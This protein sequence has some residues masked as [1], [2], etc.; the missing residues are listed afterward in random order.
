VT[1]T[2][3]ER[4]LVDLGRRLDWPEAPDLA[5]SVRAE[6]ESAPAVVVP[7]RR[8]PRRLVVLAAAALLVFGGLLA[9]SPGLRAALLE[10]LRLPGARIEIERTP[11]P[12]P[13]AAASP[14]LEDLVPGSE[15]SLAEA[16][17]TASFRVLLPSELGRPDAVVLFATGDDA[18]VTLAYRP[19]P[20]LPAADA[21]GY[22]VLLTEIRAEPT[23]ELIGKVALET[24]VEP[25]VVGGEQGYWIEGPHEVLLERGDT[26]V[27]D[28]PR[29]SASSLLWTRGPVTLRLEGDLSK[30]DALRLART[31]E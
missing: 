25:V 20:G 31:V 15:V 17:R 6:L 24:Q 16:R 28:A 10:L 27:V 13:T 23:D 21:T 4:A 1:E 5:G 3:L 2:G 22:S 12:L 11:T 26:M 19:R 8:R 9:V 30:D 7:L 29:L 18:I 14:A